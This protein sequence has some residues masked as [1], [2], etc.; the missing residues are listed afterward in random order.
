VI[1]SPLRVASRFAS[2]F[3][4][5]LKDVLDAGSQVGLDLKITSRFEP[6]SDE[7]LSARTKSVGDAEN[8]ILELAKELGK[9]GWRPDGSVQ[10]RSV[11][12]ALMKGGHLVHV[13][14][15]VRRRVVHVNL[16]SDNEE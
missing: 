13:A 10:G 7:T 11:P 3:E 1:P 5:A 16:L 8:L 9:R 15:G 6:G 12:T 14:G 2:P 4:G